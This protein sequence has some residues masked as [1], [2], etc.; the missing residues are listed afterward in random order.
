MGTAGTQVNQ[1]QGAWRWFF[2][3]AALEAGAAFV[4]LAWLPREGSA[5][6][7]SRALML[8]ALAACFLAAIGFALRPPRWLQLLRRP[9]IILTAAMLSLLLA[10]ALFLLR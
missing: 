2:G 3:L 7:G 10:V 9:S 5:I 4:A 1:T 6:S 8:G